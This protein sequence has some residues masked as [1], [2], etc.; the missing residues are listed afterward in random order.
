MMEVDPFCG[1]PV[2]VHSF[3]A[4]SVEPRPGLRALRR[5]CNQWPERFCRQSESGAQ[6]PQYR[7]RKMG[8]DPL[9]GRTSP[10]TG[11]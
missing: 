1:S 8:E 7:C 6:E 11:L 2:E 4:E 9:V 10:L 3:K 5:A